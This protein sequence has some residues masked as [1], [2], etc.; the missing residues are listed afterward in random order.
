[1][2]FRKSQLNSALAKVTK[3]EEMVCGQIS[4]G[5]GWSTGG[6]STVFSSMRQ[7]FDP[8]APAFRSP[9][10]GGLS[11][12][13]EAAFDGMTRSLTNVFTDETVNVNADYSR[14]RWEV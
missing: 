2:G 8:S 1:M 5:D 13:V 14:C 3:A 6:Q 10:A 7:G 12:Q 9:S 11:D 4:V